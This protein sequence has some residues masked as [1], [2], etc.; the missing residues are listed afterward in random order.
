MWLTALIIGLA[1]SIH[2]AGMCS[3]LAMAATVRNARVWRARLLYNGGRI[4]TY[5]IIG[6][7]ISSIGAWLPLGNFQTIAS[8][9]TGLV[10]LL[11]AVTGAYAWKI[12]I[13]SGVWMRLA[14]FLKIHLGVLLQ[15]K[16]LLTTAWLGMLNGLLPCGLTAVAWSYCITLRGPLDGFNFMLLFGLGTAPAMIGLPSVFL[17]VARSFH[18]STR[19]L[20]TSLL[21]VSAVLLIARVW[22]THPAPAATNAETDIMLCR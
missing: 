9:L 6:A 5:A 2:C 21:V 12:P 15:Q 7:A 20:T 3:P 8:L 16:G 13:L 11:M 1:G 18:I 17:W 14:S 10:L 4:L 19:V 22:L